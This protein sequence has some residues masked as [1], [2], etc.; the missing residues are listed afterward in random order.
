MTTARRL[1]TADLEA[2]VK[3]MYREVAEHP[4]QPFHLQ[5]GRSLGE[6]LG[7]PRRSR[8][9]PGR[10]DRFVWRAGVLLRPLRHLA[11]R[12]PR[13]NPRSAARSPGAASPRQPALLPRGMLRARGR[14]VIAG[15]PRD[16]SAP[17]PVP[18]GRRSA[19]GARPVDLAESPASE[20]SRVPLGRAITAAMR[21][22]GRK[23][24]APAP[25]RTVGSVGP[26]VDPP[27]PS[28]EAFGPHQ[29]VPVRQVGG[30]H[31]DAGPEGVRTK[32]SLAPLR[33]PERSGGYC[34][35]TTCKEGR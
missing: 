2:R 7:Y 20:L 27:A 22:F 1:D 5:T 19:P 6:R 10:G 32:A 4:H 26:C 18:V 9:E 34:T 17:S 35:S 12:T 14:G 15:P 31:V 13:G 11:A 30:E 16:R 8:R 25:G 21:V 24:E 28:V 29:D 33:Y 3:D 23:S